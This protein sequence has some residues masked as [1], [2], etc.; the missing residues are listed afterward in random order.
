MPAFILSLLLFFQLLT[1]CMLL[2]LVVCFN[3][4][5]QSFH[6]LQ[7]SSGTDD[8]QWLTDCCIERKNAFGRGR[9]PFQSCQCFPCFPSAPASGW[10][11]GDRNGC[12]AWGPGNAIG[13]IFNQY[14]LINVLGAKFT[15]KKRVWFLL[16]LK[17][18]L[19]AVSVCEDNRWQQG[20][21]AACVPLRRNYCSLTGRCG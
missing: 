8:L 4:I 6:I 9:L 21:R 7:W 12:T 10:H 14:W 13:L 15:K 1:V 11:P 19:S 5:T 17:W 20:S 18:S 2:L 16:W 3:L